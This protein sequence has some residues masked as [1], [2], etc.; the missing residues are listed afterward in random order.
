[1]SVRQDKQGTTRPK[2]KEGGIPPAPDGK[3][4]LKMFLQGS[5]KSLWLYNIRDRESLQRGATGFPDKEGGTRIVE[6]RT[7]GFSI[8]Q[9]GIK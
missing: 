3:D 7:S 8:H 6:K 9:L 4:C 2:I 1:M 5:S